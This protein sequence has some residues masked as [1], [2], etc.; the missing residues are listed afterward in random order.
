[1]RTVYVRQSIPIFK[2]QKCWLLNVS[3]LLRELILAVMSIKSAA[4]V[5]MPLCLPMTMDKRIRPMAEKGLGA[6]GEIDSISEWAAAALVSHKTVER[7]FVRETGL[8]PS[9]WIRQ[10]R[11][12]FAVTALSEGQSVSSVA[13]SSGYSSPSSFSYMFRQILGVVPCEFS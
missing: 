12:I 2:F 1:M 3:S 13:L 9:Q 6:P 10:A 8:T 7:L 11:L 5:E 4:T